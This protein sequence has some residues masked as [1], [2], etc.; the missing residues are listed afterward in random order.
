VGN[1]ARS[2]ETIASPE[3]E[4]LVSDDDLELA[5]EDIVRLILARMCMARHHHSRREAHLQ[6]AVCSSGIRARKAYGT[7]A[8]VEIV[9]FGSWL[10]LD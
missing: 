3:N 8:Y 10:M 4:D 6:E 7:D 2:H 9:T 1:V 5:D